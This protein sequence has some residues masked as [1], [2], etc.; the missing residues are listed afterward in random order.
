MPMCCET[1][2]S[3]TMSG[4]TMKP[5]RYL[6]LP[7]VLLL[8]GCGQMAGLGE[9]SL[10]N[11]GA[12]PGEAVAPPAEPQLATLSPQETPPV[13]KRRPGKRPRT[14]PDTAAQT[15]PEP[16]QTAEAAKPEAS[17]GGLSLASLG[18]LS[19][20]SGGAPEGGPDAVQIDKT[21]IDAYSLLAQRIK[22]CWLNPSTPR[23]LNHGFHAEMAPGEVKEA[24]M[25][26]YE[27]DADGRRG[28]TAIRVDIT[29]EFSGTLV[30]T[31]NLRLS[32]TD[33]AA[34]KADLARW[35]RGD[36]RCK[37]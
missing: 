6:M 25:L 36:D 28:V 22:Y 3:K 24:K 23:L 13:P 15:A 5:L 21:P 35:A 19:L 1:M 32:K 18:N 34:F 16:S 11:S 27:K 7:A 31:Q 10:L 12:A 26:V 37:T 29:S 33:E 2:P 30:S 9:L 4:Q 20:F 14:P 17:S 8:S